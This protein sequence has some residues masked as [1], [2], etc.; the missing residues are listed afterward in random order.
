MCTAEQQRDFALRQN[1]GGKGQGPSTREV[2]LARAL[3]AGIHLVVP[4]GKGAPFPR[5]YTCDVWLQPYGPDQIGGVAI[6][7]DGPSHRLLS[8]QKSDRRK[9]RFLREHGWHVFRCT[10]ADIDF[11]FEETVARLRK[12]IR[13]ATKS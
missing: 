8:V 13:R 10:N 9:T 4:T 2:K 12:L 5:H 6:E 11:R 3:S 7:I 1:R